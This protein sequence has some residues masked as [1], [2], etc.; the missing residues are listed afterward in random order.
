M[1]SLVS[2]VIVNW[3]GLKYLRECLDSLFAQSYANREIILVDNASTDGSPD[4]I[5]KNYPMVKVIESSSNLGFAGGTNRGIKEA[6]GELIALFNQDAVADKN[7]LEILVKAVNSSNDIAAVAG[8]IFYWGDEQERKKVFCTWPKVDPRKALAYNFFDERPA[9]DVDYLP[10][11]AM[12]IKKKALDEVGLLDEDYFLYFEETDW[13]ARAIMAGYRLVYVPDAKA[14]HVV[15]GSIGSGAKLSY[16]M[17]NR[18]R[19]ALKNFDSSYLPVFVVEF[20]KETYKMM[21]NGIHGQGF[22]DFIVRM[23]ALFWN[24][25]H[26]IGTLKARRRDLS[27]IANRKSY[28]RSL[29]LSNIE[30]EY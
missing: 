2:V 9:A 18:V 12:L 14:W 1:G 30:W 23:K 16:I 21:I 8:K 22:D 4:F 10:G 7:W 24:G 13:C 25:F 26:L 28:N 17:R 19:F 15:S 29:P 20:T 27:R 5:R 11:C 6:K 3:N